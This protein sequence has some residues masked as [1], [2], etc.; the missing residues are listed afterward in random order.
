MGKNVEFASGRSG[1]IG[2]RILGLEYLV[3]ASPITNTVAIS[4]A[5]G[6]GAYLLTWIQVH[7]DVMGGKVSPRPSMIIAT[8]TV[9]P[10]WLEER[11]DFRPGTAR[12]MADAITGMLKALRESALT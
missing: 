11:L 4:N 9:Q 5:T 7:G 1:S 8:E 2:V 6:P 10:E 12:I 3:M